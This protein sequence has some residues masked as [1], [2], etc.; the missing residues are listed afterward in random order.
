MEWA[1]PEFPRNQ[2]DRAGVSILKSVSTPDGFE[3]YMK[4]IAV[5]NNWRSSHSYPLNNFQVNLRQ[6]ARKIDASALVSQRLKRFES[7]VKKLARQ[8]TSTMELS[9]MQDIAGCRAVLSAPADVYRLARAYQKGPSGKWL[10]TL[11]GQGKDYI[12]NPKLDGYRGI[13][14]IF[15]YV[16]TAPNTGW[17]KLRVEMQLRSQHQHAWATALEAVD[18]FTKQALKANQGDTNWQRFFALMGSA[19]AMKEGA[20]LVPGTPTS[21]MELREELAHLESTLGALNRLEHFR[22]AIRQGESLPDKQAAYYLLHLSFGKRIIEWNT[23]KWSESQ[24]ANARYTQLE[25]EVSG[26]SDEHV[27]LVRAASLS[28]MK[29]AYPGFFLDTELFLRLLSE[30][31]TTPAA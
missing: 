20:A 23:F 26:K 21:A 11:V 12:Q 17:D 14:L 29:R 16:G 7:I 5:I 4:A 10:H 30:F 24:E 15:R 28:A 3:D 19:I 9:Q 25:Q 18:I 8:Q 6:R 22:H 31:L 13:H 1:K 2:V 27:V